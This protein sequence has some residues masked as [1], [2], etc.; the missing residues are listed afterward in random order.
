M[1]R[2]AVTPTRGDGTNGDIRAFMSPQ[3]NQQRRRRIIESSSSDEGDLRRDEFGNEQEDTP[4]PP[5]NAQSQ[6]QHQIVP[7]NE[8]EYPQPILFCR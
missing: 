3:P 5:A 4:S 7:N 2:S 8:N 1:P 6:Q